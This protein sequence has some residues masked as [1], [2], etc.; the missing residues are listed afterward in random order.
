MVKK[1]K[2]V[3]QKNKQK[4]SVASLLESSGRGVSNFGSLLPAVKGAEPP[5]AIAARL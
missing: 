4:E 3:L 1:L 2:S 5:T